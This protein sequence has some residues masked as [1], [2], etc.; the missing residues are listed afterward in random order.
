MNFLNFLTV[1]YAKKDTLSILVNVKNVL[2]DAK[3]AKVILITV[4][5]V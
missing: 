2:K 3:N 4:L 5:V 1:I